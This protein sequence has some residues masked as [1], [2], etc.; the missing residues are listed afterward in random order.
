MK[1]VVCASLAALL[2]AIFVLPSLTSAA[3][4]GPSASGSFQFTLGEDGQA[5]N[6]EF[7]ARVQNN[8]RTV[9]EMTF[10]DPAAVPVPDPD[11]PG[12]IANTGAII[13]ANNLRVAPHLQHLY[14]YLLENHFI[15]AI[16]DYNE[17][18]L[19]IFSRDVLARI[20]QGDS[21]WEIMVPPQ[22]ASIIKD[23]KLF[24]FPG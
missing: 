8:G 6:L 23:R 5:R 22:V 14:A 16:K 24:G 7:H 13:T 21:G 11:D 15:Q 4:D 3:K 20:R 18:Y 9:G 12:A 1:S 17:C 19:P 2:L 10:S